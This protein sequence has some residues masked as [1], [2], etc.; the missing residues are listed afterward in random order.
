MSA[1]DRVGSLRDQLAAHPYDLLAGEFIR[2]RAD[3]NDD[4]VAGVVRSVVAEGS[5]GCDEFR[6]GL[7]EA[8]TETLRLFAMRRTLLGR[9]QSSLGPLYEA[10]DAFALLPTPDDV[11]WDSWVKAALFVARSMGGDLDSVERRFEDLAEPLVERGHVA[12]EAMNRVESLDQCHLVEVTTDHGV[13]VVETMIFR[14]KSTIAFLG[15]PRQAD[16]AIEFAPS[17]NLAQLAA[18][19]ADALDASST[20]VTGPI[21]QDQLAASSFGQTASGSYL[22][23]AG[24]LSFVAENAVGSF[25]VLVAE[26]FEEMDV[27]ELAEGANQVNDQFGASDGRRLIVLSPQPSFDDDY[28]AMI[29]VHDYEDFVQTALLEPTAI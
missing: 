21:G 12:F 15:A 13:G 14:S 26:L 24:C 27:D 29:D 7:S 25:S 18:S 2:F 4:V 16:H 28:D 20:V 1:G 19:L 22:P 9:R 5:R 8:D 17:T 6:R 3:A 11:P 23:V 10:L